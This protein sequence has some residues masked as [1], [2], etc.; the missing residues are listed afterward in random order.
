MA[1]LLMQ[2]PGYGKSSIASHLFVPAGVPVVSG[3][4]QIGLVARNQAKA[5]EPLG[6]LICENYSPF[7]IDR[8]I[9][10]IFDAGLAAD[11]VKLWLGAAAGG[12]GDV[13][14]DVYVPGEYHGAVE[15]QLEE[16]GYL[17]VQLR[18]ERVGS[19]PLPEAV[20]SEQ[21]EAF[22][23]SLIE[24]PPAGEAGDRAQ[25]ECRPAGFV[26]E[27]SLRDG[28]LVIRGWAVDATGALPGQLAVRI[29]R[30]TVHPDKLDKQLRPDVQRHLG[31]PHALVGY[32]ATLDEP[33]I[34]TVADLGEGFK[35][36]VPGG[37]TFQLAGPVAD[38][39]SAAKQ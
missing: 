8:T 20:M 27:L 18:W 28:E 7:S 35:V 26:D 17:P 34:R 39:F 1:Y 23:L 29:G 3:D 15:Q 38:I 25:A 4:Q 10:R 19:A 14:L 12:A 6:S 22:Y 2:P 36:F 11:L 32:R 31:L 13:A 33:G 21:A 30:R 9:E 16:L 24:A 5:P 37:V